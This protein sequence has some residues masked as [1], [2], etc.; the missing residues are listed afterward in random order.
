ME[1]KSTDI[2]RRPAKRRRL[3]LPL[4]NDQTAP[5]STT[6]SLVLGGSLDFPFNRLDLRR[7]AGYF[8]KISDVKWPAVFA[9]PARKDAKTPLVVDVSSS[10][11]VIVCERHLTSSRL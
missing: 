10:K 7:K 2:Q 1:S 5:E 9:L 8:A 11:S 4:I 6:I 3:S